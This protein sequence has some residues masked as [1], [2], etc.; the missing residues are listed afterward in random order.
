VSLIILF[1]CLFYILQIT[2]IIAKKYLLSTYRVNKYIL[3]FLRVLRVIYV[4]RRKYF[5]FVMA[6]PCF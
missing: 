2:I 6:Q 5:L 4:S 3:S 1:V